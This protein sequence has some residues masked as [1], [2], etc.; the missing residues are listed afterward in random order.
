LIEQEREEQREVR[1]NEV[2]A[3]EPQIGVA[4][5]AVCIQLTKKRSDRYG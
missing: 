5:L 1:L 4:L 3:K 2:M